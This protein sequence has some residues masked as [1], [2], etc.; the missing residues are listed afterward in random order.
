MGTHR[1]AAKGGGDEPG[2]PGQLLLQRLAREARHRRDPL[3]RRRFEAQARAA[4]V[5]KEQMRQVLRTLRTVTEAGDD[6]GTRG[7][8]TM[9]RAYDT[10]PASQRRS[11]VES[12]PEAPQPVLDRL[13][14]LSGI[15]G[16]IK[17]AHG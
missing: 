13:Y 10:S 8:R 16:G 12:G 15:L 9:R 11:Y 7:S 4:E 3:A 2:T 14:A 17:C 6:T 5:Q 1:P